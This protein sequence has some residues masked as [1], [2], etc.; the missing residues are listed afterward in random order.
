MSTEASLSK[1][2]KSSA[3]LERDDDILE[4]HRLVQLVIQKLFLHKGEMVRAADKAMSAFWWSYPYGQP[5]AH[6]T[7]ATYLAVM[8]T[9]EVYF[10][11][12]GRWNDMAMRSTALDWVSVGS[13]EAGHSSQQEEQATLE[14][15]TTSRQH[16]DQD[17][18]SWIT[19]GPQKTSSDSLDLFL[20]ATAL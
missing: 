20:W 15:A 11:S 7:L 18:S 1:L 8:Q 4:M 13:V 2:K 16:L 19:P 10:E 9:L 3:L 6:S 17:T 14:S 12:R 5:I